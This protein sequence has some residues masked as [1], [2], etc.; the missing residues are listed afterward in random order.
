[1]WLYHRSTGQL[2]APG[3]GARLGWICGWFVALIQLIVITLTLLIGSPGDFMQ[4]LRDQLAQAYPEQTP[5]V[6][7]A[8]DFVA[9]PT[10]VTILILASL[11]FLT[12]PPALGGLIG[13]RGAAGRH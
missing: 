1:M 5:E 10:G 3:K 6:T 13:A 2:L 4:Q 12:L 7:Q 8:L 11:I 9:T